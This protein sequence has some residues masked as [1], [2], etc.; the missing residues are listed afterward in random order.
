MNELHQP[1]YGDRQAT[2]NIFRS[3]FSKKCTVGHVVVVKIATKEKPEAE[4]E[5]AEITISD[6]DTPPKTETEEE[7]SDTERMERECLSQQ[8]G[9]CCY[10]RVG[11]QTMN[12]EVRNVP[13]IQCDSCHGWLHTDCAGIHLTELGTDSSFN[14]GCQ[15]K[16]PYHLKRTRAVAKE[17]LLESVLTDEEI[18]K[19]AHDLRAGVLRSN[20]M[21]LKQHPNFSLKFKQNREALI[22]I[23]TE[24]QTTAIIYR[25]HAVMRHN[26]GDLTQ[27]S[28]NL[29]V[30]TPELTVS[31][32][33]KLEGFNRYQAEKAFLSHIIFED[34]NTQKEL[35]D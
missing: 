11:N 3:V 6:D 24:K 9:A 7:Q 33:R 27:L 19:L 5:S 16:L 8:L 32:L 13:W 2:G 18:Q 35:E 12:S 22:S 26:K 34:E 4:V 17:C 20:R 14:C 1:G 29:E 15:M 30:M 28:F 21:F 23:F 10:Q 31:I 25:V